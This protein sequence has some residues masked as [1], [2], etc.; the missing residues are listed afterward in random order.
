MMHAFLAPF[1]ALSFSTVADKETQWE[2]VDNAHFYFQ[3]PDYLEVMEDLNDDAAY[4]Y[5]AVIPVNSK[6]MELY[7]L[8]IVEAKEEIESFNLGY[9]LDALSYWNLAVTNLA[10]GVD[11]MKILTREPYIENRHDITLTRGNIYGRMGR[12]RVHYHLGVYEG[13]Y[14]F[15]QVLC[16]TL[17]DQYKYYKAD[18]ET[19]VE[20][21]REK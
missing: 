4:Q 8:V 7:V 2:R 21:F 20:S 18:M 11:K 19:I 3:I 5:G 9:T 6:T 14:A 13:E 17:S 12:V 15:Y 10:T 1:F 16:W